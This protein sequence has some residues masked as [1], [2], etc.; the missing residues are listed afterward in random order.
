MVKGNRQ[1]P[2]SYTPERWRRDAAR[3]DRVRT[4]RGRCD[5]EVTGAKNGAR[6]VAPLMRRPM[7]RERS[8]GRARCVDA[9]ATRR[10]RA[11][12]SSARRWI[13]R[14]V[15]VDARARRRRARGASASA[16]ARPV[17]RKRARRHRECVWGGRARLRAHTYLRR[18]LSD[19]EGVELRESVAP[20]TSRTRIRVVR[21][22]T[23]RTGRQ[24]IPG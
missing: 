8:N 15:D 6:D 23:G 7:R 9:R 12:P 24:F 16:S 21:R 19:H 17:T 18:T 5:F 4:R 20:C 22:L 11:I 10:A 13:A 2:R 14:A 3:G 1:A